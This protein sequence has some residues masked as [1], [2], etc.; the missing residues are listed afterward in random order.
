MRNG[1]KS[2]VEGRDEIS[3]SIKIIKS[4]YTGLFFASE[5]NRISSVA[6][7][8]TDWKELEMVIS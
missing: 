3:T 4:G 2:M 8:K 6:S 1:L 7:L 5:K